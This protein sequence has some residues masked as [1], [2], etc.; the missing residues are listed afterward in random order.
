LAPD[1]ICFQKWSLPWRDKGFSVLTSK[2]CYIGT[3]SFSRKEFQKCFQ[4]W[5]KCVA[6]QGKYV[7]GDSF[8]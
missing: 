8:Q 6:A 1:D 5:A 2:K 3:G 4:L 7:K